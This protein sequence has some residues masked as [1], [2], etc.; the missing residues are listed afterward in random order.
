MEEHHKPNNRGINKL[1]SGK[2]ATKN[3]TITIAANIGSNGRIT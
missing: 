1:K 3:K 2:K